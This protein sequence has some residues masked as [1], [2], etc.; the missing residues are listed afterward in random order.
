MLR[1]ANTARRHDDLAGI[2]LGVSDQL[3]NGL[4]WKRRVYH[5]DS[6]SAV[7]ARN[8]RDVANEVETEVVIECH[9]PCVMCTDLEERIAVGRRLHDCL[10]GQIAASAH[11]V[12]D[13]E[14]LAGALRQP[15]T[16]QTG[17]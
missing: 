14:W 9:V 8:R 4:R 12:L 15:L 6:R 5:Q 7:D 2:G 1:A 10:G 3:G 11:P 16:D 17:E 13:D